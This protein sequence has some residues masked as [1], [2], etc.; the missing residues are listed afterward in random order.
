VNL[1][2]GWGDP[3]ATVDGGVATVINPDSPDLLG[4]FC[5]DVTVGYGDSKTVAFTNTRLPSTGGTRT[6]GYWK[7]WSSCTKGMQY[8]KATNAGTPE[9][10]LDYY[11]GGAGDVSIWPIGDIVDTNTPTADS[12]VI[13]CQQA[14]NLLSKSALNGDKRPGDPIY[15][16]VAQLLGAKLNVA[17]G[18]G[19][20]PALDQALI[21]AQLL[22]DAI[23]FDG[24]A[25]YSG[26]NKTVTL[27][28][29]QLSQATTLAGILG[30][31]NEGTLGGTCPTHV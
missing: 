18:A 29:A 4:N 10:T 13:T 1:Q 8:I 7:N 24:T 25:S 6:I 15:N 9:A 5:V 27:T 20:C 28:A 2:A 21:D 11:L 12:P 19:T 16:M 23:N 17:A 26:K 31:Y 14:V 22:L 30:S 3:S